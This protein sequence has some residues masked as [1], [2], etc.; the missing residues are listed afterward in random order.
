MNALRGFSYFWNLYANK[1]SGYPIDVMGYTPPSFPLP[2]NYSF[3]S[4]GKFSDFPSPRWSDGF[5]Y[6]L[7]MSQDP[8]VL[9]VLEDYWQL[10]PIDTLAILLFEELML[11]DES[12]LRFDLS[13]D[14]LYAEGARDYRSLA[15]YDVIETDHS[16]PYGIS[17]QAGL[18]RRDLLKQIVV[19]NESAWEFEMVGGER[20]KL[21]PDWKILGSRQVPMK[22][23]ISVQSGKLVLDGGYQSPRLDTLLKENE[24]HFDVLRSS[25][26]LE[27]L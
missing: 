2:S 26:Y 4:I 21:H 10:R 16:V 7:Q 19:P 5:H 13:S 22:Y 15:H 23:L 27:G 9:V 12:I 25:G 8:I 20:L 6:M 17:L 18:W 14:R 1:L 3:R 11:A 24:I